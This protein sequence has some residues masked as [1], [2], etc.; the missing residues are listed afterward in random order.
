MWEQH[1]IFDD[2]G[3]SHRLFFQFFNFFS[4]VEANTH[5][6]D[7]LCDFPELFASTK[8]LIQTLEEELQD[9]ISLSLF[10]APLIG[11]DNVVYS[12][13]TIARWVVE[14]QWQVGGL[15]RQPCYLMDCQPHKDAA[16]ALRLLAVLGRMV[17]EEKCVRPTEVGV[18]G[19][20][21]YSRVC[22]VGP[23]SVGG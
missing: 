4:Q 6:A 13:A 14:N 16:S 17:G 20:V 15:H 21:F 10:E 2:G 1:I 23:I 18:F 3:G 5:L 8:K 22:F 11:P 12:A 19:E 9:G 7:W